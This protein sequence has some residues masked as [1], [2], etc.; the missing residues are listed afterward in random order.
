MN[1]ADCANDEENHKEGKKSKRDSLFRTQPKSRLAAIALHGLNCNACDSII[2]HLRR[3]Q[4]S[5]LCKMLIK[6]LNEL[7]DKFWKAVDK[8]RS[9]LNTANYK[10]IVP[11][12]IWGSSG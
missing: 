2:F 9:N 4:E 12:V 5:Y 11:G 7:D 1:T 3:E 6:F 10:H 8:L